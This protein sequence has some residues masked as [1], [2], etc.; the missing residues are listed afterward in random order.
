MKLAAIYNVWDGVELLRGSIDCIRDHVDL[1]IFVYQKKS[2]FGEEYN[3]LD[4]IT[5]SGHVG[6]K[7]DLTHLNNY[8]RPAI[9]FTEYR[10]TTIGGA[11]NEKEKRNI[12]I[13]IARAEGCTHFLHLD[14]DEYYK[15]F[16]EAKKMFIDSGKDGSVCK[17]FTYF[18][19]PTFRFKNPDGYFVPFIHKL[20]E[21]TIA[22]V[23][24]YPFY[25][26]PTRRINETNVIELP[27]FMHH[28]SWVRHD[29]ERKI[30][31]SSARNNILKGTAMEDYRSPLLLECPEDYYVRDFDQRLTVVDNYFNINL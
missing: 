16:F 27:V 7:C 29:I 13:R 20:K 2:N 23:K 21:D 6:R 25:V 17:L 26:D 12:G 24:T 22:G 31:N 28:F 8:W 1:I 11:S 15:N 18:K 10:P 19:S 4:D 9:I 3:P 30:R 5:T 14:N